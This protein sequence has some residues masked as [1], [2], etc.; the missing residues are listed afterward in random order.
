MEEIFALSKETQYNPSNFKVILDMFIDFYS[1]DKNLKFYPKENNT[2][3]NSKKEFMINFLTESIEFKKIL[4]SKL[5]IAIFDFRADYGT[6]VLK[7]RNKFDYDKITLV[8]ICLDSWKLNIKPQSRVFTS[9]PSDCPKVVYLGCVNVKN[10]DSVI[11]S[12]NIIIANAALEKTGS[13]RSAVNQNGGHQKTPGWIYGVYENVL[14]S[15]DNKLKVNQ[16]TNEIKPKGGFTDVG[17]HTGGEKRMTVYPLIK[18]VLFYFFQY[19]FQYEKEKHDLKKLF[20]YNILLFEVFI[21]EKDYKQNKILNPDDFIQMIHSIADKGQKLIDYS[22]ELIQ[23]I[24][25]R[26]KTIYD[27]VIKKFQFSQELIIPYSKYINL[28]SP[29]LL[30]NENTNLDLLKKDN[31]HTLAMNNLELMGYIAINS[32]FNYFYGR[33]NDSSISNEFKISYFE[34]FFFEKMK[35]IKVNGPSLFS[36]SEVLKLNELLL[37]YD[38]MIDQLKKKIKNEIISVLNSH[39]AL[40]TWGFYI[41]IHQFSK[42]KYVLLE[43]YS[44]P[45]DEN[46]LFYL[47]L[48]DKLAIDAFIGISNYLKYYHNSK[49]KIFSKKKGEIKGTYMFIEQ[50]FIIDLF[51][52]DILKSHKEKSDKLNKERYEKIEKRRRDYKIKENICKEE[53]EKLG[54]LIQQL[55]KIP[56]TNN[57]LLND[58]NNEIS[59]K[60]RII[61]R[62]KNELRKLRYF[63]EVIIH[64]VSNIDMYAKNGIFFLYMPILLFELYRFGFLSYSKLNNI[65]NIEKDSISDNNYISYYKFYESLNITYRNPNKDID[66]FINKHPHE[67]QIGNK[68]IFLIEDELDG[69]WYPEDICFLSWKNINPFLL[70][71][72]EATSY[73][74]E[75]I[76][77]PSL[78]KMILLSKFDYIN[79]DRGNLWVADQYLKPQNWTK[80]QYASFCQMRSYPKQQLEKFLYRMMENKLKLSDSNFHILIREVLFHIGPLDNNHSEYKVNSLV[81]KF[82]LFESDYMESLK[83]VLS[84]LLEEIK[85][86]PQNF[87]SL[88]I[89]SQ[90]SGYLSQYDISFL[91]IRRRFTLAVLEW[92]KNT[93]IQINNFHY[94]GEIENKTNEK[95]NQHLYIGYC[96]LTM[97]YGSLEENDYEIF[98][99]LIMKFHQTKPFFNEIINDKLEKLVYLCISKRYQDIRENI[100]TYYLNDAIVN[101]LFNINKEDLMSWKHYNGDN[102][103]YFH[104]KTM[105]NCEIH[106]NLMNGILLFN[107]IPPNNLQN[108]ILKHKLYID[109]FGLYNCFVI[110]N[111]D[112][113]LHTIYPI[114]GR[115]YIFLSRNMICLLMRFW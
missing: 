2:L 111:N 34:R 81:W 10:E 1:N 59:E 93:Q 45:L 51:L 95:T 23:N 83:T 106:V 48:R 4:S 62:L 7:I 57:S 89:L 103:E 71:S 46:D 19:M 12:V 8:L 53:E 36:Q 90:I 115:N 92:I 61:E 99:Y 104:V 85:D 44:V 17:L 101:I 15:I 24:Y 9:F 42:S 64:P 114:F 98:P 3:E 96:I 37:L 100:K 39:L 76:S 18:N 58:K 79:K 20:D 108:E 35:N 84:N 80:E 50:Y 52:M 25:K 26:I 65:D 16:N 74:T 38:K 54:I 41:F 73:F 94:N 69:V 40:I 6:C 21:L 107:G 49:P 30:I 70:N 29:N 105:N 27:Q 31:I 56:Y 112:G 110:R 77:I 14:L 55:S 43:N 47:R 33:I 32:D 13:Q 60:K 86:S 97:E 66:Y 75:K 78:Q 113:S 109:V 87:E 102:K 28:S 5:E 63:N 22:E 82:K 11:S 68:D 88:L 67:N 72:N 91:Q